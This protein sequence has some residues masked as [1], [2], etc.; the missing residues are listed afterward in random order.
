MS[1]H[2]RALLCILAGNALTAGTLGACDQDR[3]DARAK[4]DW[5]HDGDTLSLDAGQRVRI[6]GMNAPEIARNGNPG[7]PYGKKARR[8]MKSLLAKSDYRV[9]LQ[10]GKERE[11]RHG[12]MLAH[13]YLSDERSLSAEML[14][15][16]L[17]VAITVPPNDWNLN[18]YRQAEAQARQKRLG[19]WTF[20]ELQTLDSDR[21]KGDERGFRVIEGTVKSTAKSRYSTWLNLKGNLGIHIDHTDAP[22]F[23]AMEISKLKGRRIGVRGWL[24]ERHDRLRMQL[25][26]PADLSV[27]N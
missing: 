19:I 8:V 4:V 25:R 9:R 15:R 23:R 24:Y 16:G 20:S 13:V 2:F 17:A 3:I 21:L 1:L 18:C 10:Y 26:H 27:V 12:R 14:R 7:Q 11:D 22:Y 5:V 6:I